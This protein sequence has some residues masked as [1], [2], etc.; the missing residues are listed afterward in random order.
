MNFI[1]CTGSAFSTIIFAVI[2]KNGMRVA[3]TFS[4]ND[5]C[6]CWVF[7]LFLFYVSIESFTLMFK[8]FFA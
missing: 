1:A 8:L 7:Y 3:L 6:T 4:P 5:R 2:S